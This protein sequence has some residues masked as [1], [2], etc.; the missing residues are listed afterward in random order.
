MKLGETGQPGETEEKRDSLN[1]VIFLFARLGRGGFTASSPVSLSPVTYAMYGDG[2][3]GL[4]EQHAV[5]ADAQTQQSFELA[6]QRLHPA[7]TG[8]GVAVQR[9]QNP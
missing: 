7:L 3:F 6:G 4:V 8:L 9:P 1:A 5:V 2:I